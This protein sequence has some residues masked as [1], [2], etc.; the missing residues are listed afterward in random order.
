MI[1]FY[2]DKEDKDFRDVAGAMASAFNTLRFE[3]DK[4]LD[5][6]LQTI[7]Q[8]RSARRAKNK[9]VEYLRGLGQPEATRLANMV[10]TGQLTG[11]QAYSQ[12]FALE[13]EKRAA[14]RAA[15]NAARSFD[16]QLKLI[17]YRHDKA[18]ELQKLQD[19]KPKDP[20]QYQQ[21]AADIL[22][23][24]LADTPAEALKMALSSNKNVTNVNVGGGSDKQVFDAVAE[25][26]DAA[27]KARTS[28]RS[29]DEA[30]KA[31]SNMFAGLGAEQRLQAAKL[32]AFTGFKGFDEAIQNTETF[33]TQI[34]PQVAFLLKQTVGS[35]QV[36][37]ADRRFATDAAAGNITFE[38]ASIERVLDIM[39]RL[40][41][42]VVSS[43]SSLLDS[44]YPQG[45]NF[46][47]ERA[48][49]EVILDNQQTAPN[50]QASTPSAKVTQMP[51]GTV[52][53]EID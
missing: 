37:D 29:L 11:Q 17:D 19:A 24:G 45:Q 47:R 21:K 52:I 28:L 25:S 20:F 51:D 23:A 12:I 39:E 33:K 8:Q 22:A 1:P 2:S 15:G 36:S 4:G 38:Q 46:G 42:E 13:Q 16:N 34:A 27:K 48:L 53:E 18:L 31:A 10:E 30:S 40:S 26:A 32:F 43:H 44:V 3:P 7:K 35:T 9:T 41:K 50:S 14:D 49:F 5:T 6:A